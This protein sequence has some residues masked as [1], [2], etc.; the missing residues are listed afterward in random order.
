MVGGA[1]AQNNNPV[2]AAKHGLKLIL[3][4]RKR[5]Y[6]IFNRSGRFVQFFKH[7]VGVTAQIEALRRRGARSF[8]SDNPLQGF[9]VNF[10]A[11]R[12]DIR[13]IPVVGHAYI[14]AFARKRG[15][16]ACAEVFSVAIA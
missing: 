6:G 2:N 5:A 14:R 13:K 12:G 11:V 3:N 15:L 7:I 9:V 1:A 16:V 8:F 4:R 10:Y